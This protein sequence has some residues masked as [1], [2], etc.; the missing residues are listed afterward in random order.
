MWIWSVPL[1]V[2]V[3][4][5]VLH[6][7]TCWCHVLL[8]MKPSWC[9]KSVLCLRVLK[10]VMM[11]FEVLHYT[12]CDGWIN[13]GHGYDEF[14]NPIPLTYGSFEEAWDDLVDDFDEWQ[15]QID[16][17]ERPADEGYDSA[18]FMIAP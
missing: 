8:D 9:R 2:S 11:R 13:A 14:D 5:F 17:G 1:T 6:S 7:S 12:L 18:E 16:T 15:H 4:T 3:M 10:E